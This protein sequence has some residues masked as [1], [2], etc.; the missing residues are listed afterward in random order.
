[1][2]RSP[3]A[4]WTRPALAPAVDYDRAKPIQVHSPSRGLTRRVSAMW[5]IAKVRC[6]LVVI[7]M[8]T[9]GVDYHRV[10]IST[11]ARWQHG[12]VSLLLAIR[13]RH[14]GAERAIR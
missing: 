9:T 7:V 6:T 10:S 1:M 13:G 14:C 5:P 12:H 4:R 8:C 2:N 3:L 11:F